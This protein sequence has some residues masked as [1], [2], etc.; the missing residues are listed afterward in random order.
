MIDAGV[1][2]VVAT[3]PLLVS[4]PIAVAAGALSFFSPCCL[5]L[6]PGYLSYVTGLTG[7]NLGSGEAPRPQPVPVT[8]PERPGSVAT[9]ERVRTPAAATQVRPRTVVGAALFVLGFAAVFTSYGAAFGGL[10]A[11][12]ATH[13]AVLVRVLGGITIALGL[14]FVGAYSRIPGLRVTGRTARMQYRP[15]MGLAGAPVL[16]VLFGLGWTPCIGPTLAAVLALSSTTGTAG[17]GAVLAFAYAAGLGIP[18]L[19]AALALGRMMR[20]V[21]FARRHAR[22]VMRL[23]GAMLIT[24]G[25]LQVSGVWTQLIARLQ[26]WIGGTTMP[27]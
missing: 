26:G 9:A 18:F 14:V 4:L 24:V 11:A 17:R 6:V 16:G 15:A 23:G 12:L 7:A 8:P 3:A 10:G 22:S 1:T 13:Q 5:P 19:L 21:A 25:V 2:D 27:L 20:A